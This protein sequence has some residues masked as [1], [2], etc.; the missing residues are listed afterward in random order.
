MEKHGGKG[1]SILLKEDL[2][3]QRYMLK[4]TLRHP[5][6]NKAKARGEGV[7]FQTFE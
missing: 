3:V 5:I 4:Q 6:I 7:L 2:K 1:C